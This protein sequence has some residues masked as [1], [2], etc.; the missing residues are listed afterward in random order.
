MS[1]GSVLL[2]AAVNIVTFGLIALSFTAMKPATPF[3]AVVIISLI[4]THYVLYR[5]VQIR[6]A[7][8]K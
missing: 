4:V 7:G 1:A 6:K 3:L 2:N 8:A 5:L